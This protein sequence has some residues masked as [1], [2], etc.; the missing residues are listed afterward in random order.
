MSFLKDEINECK[1]IGYPIIKTDETNKI[2]W[3]L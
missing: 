3:N 2:Y 1:E